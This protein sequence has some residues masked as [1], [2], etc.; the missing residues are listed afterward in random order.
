M[1]KGNLE[2]I[3]GLMGY[4]RLWIDS[5]ALKMKALYFKLPD[6]EPD[7]LLWKPEELQSMDTLKQ[8]SVLSWC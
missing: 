1:L 7:G 5:Y 8:A 4:C 6:E 3:W 2:K